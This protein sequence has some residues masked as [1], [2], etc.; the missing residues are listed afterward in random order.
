MKIDRKKVYDKCD[1]HCGYC[2]RRNSLLQQNT[3]SCGCL[4]KE[5]H[6]FLKQKFAEIS[7]EWNNKIKFKEI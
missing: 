7:N 4:K 5:Y 3:R 2:G 6:T 1:G